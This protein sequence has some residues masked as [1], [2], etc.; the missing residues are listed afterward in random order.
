M[1][2]KDL[3]TLTDA[4]LYCRAGD[5]YIDPWR[6]VERAVITHAHGDHARWGM[7]N[8][9]CA[10][11]GLAVLRTRM[12]VDAR[13]ETVEYGEVR[14]VNGV[15][16]SLHPAGHILGSS[17]VRVEANGEVWVVSGDYKVEPDPTCTPFE[18]V[19][20]HTFVTESTFGLPIYQWGD[21][22]ECFESINAWWRHNQQ[23]GKT[24]LLFGYSLGKAQRV[25][26]GLD[27]SIGPIFVHGAIQRLNEGYRWAG[28][29]LPKTKLATQVEKGFDWS[30]AMVVAP[31]SANGTP[32][33]R[34]MGDVTTG[35]ASGWMQIRGI[36]RR[37]SVDRGF[38]LSDH[39][40]WPA[41]LSTIYATGAEKIWVTHGYS[42]I[43][44]RY[45]LE[46]GLQ[47]EVVPTRFKGEAIEAEE[48]EQTPTEQKQE[49]E[50]A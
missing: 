23:V 26:A 33:L 7:E 41:L 35:F 22:Q 29:K 19:K 48:E 43:V 46:Q 11:P 40:D 3:L 32:W 45:L 17:Q 25:L 10:T 28:I 49:E 31:P 18:L 12:G 4:G 8:Y 42:N 30:Q 39:V 21:E 37:R 2:E 38:A 44:V 16:L 1:R 6:P 20:C 15:K 9:L 34:R 13:I 47:A 36:R 5:F 50:S 24:S 14:T 27:D